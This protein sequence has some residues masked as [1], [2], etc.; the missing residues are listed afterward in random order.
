MPDI[1]NRAADLIYG[2]GIITAE[3]IA[4][5]L[6]RRLANDLTTQF[7]TEAQIL[8]KARNILSEFE[9]L[10]AESLLNTDLAAWIAGFDQVRNKLP[11]WAQDSWK[12]WNSFKQ[13]P[14]TWRGTSLGSAGDEPV[15]RFPLWE[16]AA[17]SI[18]ERKIVTRAEFDTL[19]NEAKQ[20]AFT[21]AGDMSEKTIEKIRDTLHETLVEGPSLEGFKSRLGPALESS[22]IGPGH[23]ENVFRTNTQAAFSDGF[24]GIAEDP[25]V[26]ELFPYWAY[27]AIHDARTREEH[28]DLEHLGLNGTNIYRADDPMW[29]FFT[30]PWSWQCRCGRTPMTIESAARAGVKE[31]QHWLATGQKPLI[32]EWCI[33]KIHFRPPAGFVGGRRRVAA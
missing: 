29:E 3:S 12:Q 11:D 22:F 23:L 30:P 6:R 20:R 18:F 28:L 14:P 24:N 9:P 21:V 31:A 10:L 15:I 19:T 2:R 33:D 7:M 16:R 4:S 32:P 8:D 26:Q 5:E 25:I 1:R 13:P 17:E 27:N